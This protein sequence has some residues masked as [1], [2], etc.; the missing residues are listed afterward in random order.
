M[1]CKSIDGIDVFDVG[2]RQILDFNSGV[3][4]LID[5]LHG[6]LT[7][8]Q[9]YGFDYVVV[10][11]LF[12]AGGVCLTLDVSYCSDTAERCVSWCKSFLAQS[13]VFCKHAEVWHTVD[14][15]ELWASWE[16]EV[17]RAAVEANGTAYHLF[18]SGSECRVDVCERPPMLWRVSWYRK[19][20]LR[21]QSWYAKR[22]DFVWVVGLTR[23]LGAAVMRARARSLHDWQGDGYR[24]CV[25]DDYGYDDGYNPV[26]VSVEMCG[27]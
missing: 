17:G 26:I 5:D 9:R 25:L 20:E 10:T 12:T 13:S 7:F 15:A 22:D 16:Y 2:K 18:D 4:V 27:A 21:Y 6:W 23:E 3:G 11:A 14:D 8:K 19:G 24:W 1:F